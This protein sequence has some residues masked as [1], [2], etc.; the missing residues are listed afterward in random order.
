MPVGKFGYLSALHS[1]AIQ[2]I[3]PLDKIEQFKEFHAYDLYNGKGVFEGVEEAKRF[4][5]IQVLLTA[6][7]L[8]ELPFVY[9]AVD[10]KKIATSPFSLVR[11]LHVALHMCLLG[12]EDWATGNHPNYSGGSTKQIDWKDSYLCI[13]DDCDD[14]ALKEQF[15]KTY[16]TLRVK[17]PFVPPNTNRLWHGHDDMFFADSK[18]C[19]GIQIS[20]ICNYFVR[21]HLAGDADEQKF[22]DI[23]AD[24]VICAKPEPEWTTY[25]NLLWNS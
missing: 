4:T 25:Q 8:Y 16:R 18:D 7:R 23:F 2:Q 5:A 9:A 3:L 1:A 10:R 22:Y 6:V 11:P 21:R 15:R 14:K 13:L 17:H 24:Q 20:D 19:L 12:I